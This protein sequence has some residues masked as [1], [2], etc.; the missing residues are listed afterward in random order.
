MSR[1]V[2]GKL[3]CVHGSLTLFSF[4]IF[5]GTMDRKS[6]VTPHRRNMRLFQIVTDTRSITLQL[7]TNAQ[8]FWPRL[9]HPLRLH[10]T[11]VAIGNQDL[12]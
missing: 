12:E 3:F 2:N 9:H 5:F 1:L 8:L 10:Y 7:P 11:S 6:V 4:S